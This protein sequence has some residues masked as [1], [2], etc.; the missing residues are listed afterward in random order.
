MEEGWLGYIFAGFFFFSAFWFWKNPWNAFDDID[1]WD[2]VTDDNIQHFRQTRLLWTLGFLIFS[3]SLYHTAEAITTKFG[4]FIS[5]PFAGSRAATIEEYTCEDVERFLKKTELANVFGRK[6]KV[7]VVTEI[8][9]IGRTESSIEC[10]ATSMLSSG[11]DVTITA[12]IE[13]IDG[14]FFLRASVDN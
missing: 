1:G 13:S 14:Q 12:K 2:D 6:F 10:N 8:V 4:K 5:D 9:E 7:L 3:F 11:S